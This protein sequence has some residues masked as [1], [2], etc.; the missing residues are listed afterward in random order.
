MTLRDAHEAVAQIRRGPVE[1]VTGRVRSGGTHAWPRRGEE[2]GLARMT[3]A[4][5]GREPHKATRPRIAWS[6]RRSPQDSAVVGCRL[7]SSTRLSR[8]A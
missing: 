3:K 1:S 7:T 2:L 8:V 4:A 6:A 5:A